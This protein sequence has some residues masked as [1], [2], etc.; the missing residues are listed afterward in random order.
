ME[1]FK[2][3]SRIRDNVS[4]LC[5]TI[6]DIVVNREMD[7][8]ECDITVMFAVEWDDGTKCITNLHSELELV[9]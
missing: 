1:Q 6:R 8:E 7:F 3:G 9:N 2:I 4:N 5:G